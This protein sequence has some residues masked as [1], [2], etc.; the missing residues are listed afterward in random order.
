MPD[1]Y[2]LCGKIRKCVEPRKCQTSTLA[3]EK[4]ASGRGGGS[5]ESIL[6]GSLH[7]VKA[8]F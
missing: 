3:L 8:S 5:C 7:E 1:Y 6:R 4:K 2:G